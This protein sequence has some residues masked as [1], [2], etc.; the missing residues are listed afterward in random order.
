MAVSAA[1]RNK[2]GGRCDN[3]SLSGQDVLFALAV[4]GSFQSAFVFAFVDPDNQKMILGGF[5]DMAYRFGFDQGNSF[6][7][8]PFESTQGGRDLFPPIWLAAWCGYCN[9]GGK[10]SD[11]WLANK[12]GI[13]RSKA[14]TIRPV[15][16]DA[17][18]LLHSTETDVAL[19]L[20][21]RLHGQ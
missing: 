20:Y 10:V 11:R 12:I 2:K 18:A 1:S 15:V 9:R 16:D 13:G 5:S 7:S 21:I 4:L 17:V 19:H 3:L 14:R 6:R 8:M